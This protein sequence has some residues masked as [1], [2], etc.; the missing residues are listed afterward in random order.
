[1]RPAEDLDDNNPTVAAP[2]LDDALSFEHVAMV[3][4]RDHRQFQR[5]ISVA[6]S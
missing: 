3:G 2:S 4:A 1:M 5:A 6:Q